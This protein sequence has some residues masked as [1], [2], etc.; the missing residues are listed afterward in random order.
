[1]VQIHA[2][3]SRHTGRTTFVNVSTT[4]CG[5]MPRPTVRLACHV[6][7]SPCTTLCCRLL[8]RDQRAPEQA[9]KLGSRMFYLSSIKSR[10]GQTA[11]VRRR[12]HPSSEDWHSVGMISS[13]L[14]NLHYV[15]HVHDTKE[16]LPH[17]WAPSTLTIKTQSSEI[18]PVLQRAL[19][20]RIHMQDVNGDQTH[21]FNVSQ[22]ANTLKFT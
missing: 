18:N 10:T 15:F 5:I 16:T 11:T 7:P 17:L 21:Y 12:T 13:C 1:M 9:S 3:F 6:T 8:R 2:A 20:R 14:C 22:E 19:T 4:G